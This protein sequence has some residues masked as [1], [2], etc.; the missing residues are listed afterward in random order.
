MLNKLKTKIKE[1]LCKHE[2]TV[3]SSCPY[4]MKTYTYCNLCNKRVRVSQT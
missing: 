1:K 3:D 2:R 4:T